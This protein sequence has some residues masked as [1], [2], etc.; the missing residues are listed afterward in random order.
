MRRKTTLN[1]GQVICFSSWN[2]GSEG[3]E[4]KSRALSEKRSL[5]L[6]FLGNVNKRV[7]IH[8]AIRLKADI[9]KKAISNVSCPSFFSG[10]EGADEDE[11]QSDM[12]LCSLLGML[13]GEIE[14]D[15]ITHLS[16]SDASLLKEEFLCDYDSSDTK[17]MAK[18]VNLRSETSDYQSYGA[19][20]EGERSL[21]SAW[22]LR[23]IKAGKKPI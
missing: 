21:W 11:D 23:N 4:W 14:T 8:D 22:Y 5:A 20:P 7:S 12:S 10:I 15:C 3:Y 6:E 17:R 1:I 9:N 18:W 16:P 2:D 13:E 19:I